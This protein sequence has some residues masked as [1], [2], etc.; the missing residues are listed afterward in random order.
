MKN[1]TRIAEDTSHRLG[2]LTK[3]LKGWNLIAGLFEYTRS[4][5]DDLIHAYAREARELVLLSL[6][7]TFE[8]GSAGIKGNKSRFDHLLK[9]LEE[10]DERE[11]KLADLCREVMR[12][13]E[14]A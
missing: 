4:S 1:K 2:E 8:L 10:L 13:K 12:R 9:R 6:R 14:N 5:Q 7:L 11:Q 3:S